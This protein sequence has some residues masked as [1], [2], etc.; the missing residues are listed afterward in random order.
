MKQHICAEIVPI[1]KQLSE[2]D[3]LKIS[4][5]TQHKKVTKGELLFTPDNQNE[6]MILASGS[7]KIYQLNKNGKEQLLRVMQP[8]E[9]EGEKAL[10]GIENQSLYAT[11]LK[12]STL[13][14]LSKTKFQE[15]L[16][17]YPEISQHLL[18]DFATKIGMLERQVEL[19]NS[20][21]VESKLATY[22]LDLSVDQRSQTVELPFKLKELATYL[23]TTPE[24]LSRKLRDLEDKKLILKK[25]LTITILN[26]DEL[27][28]IF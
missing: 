26:S 4:A 8:G 7:I 19:F 21:S 3:L 25:H 14:T 20:E 11:A 10:Y 16:S 1:F 22:I 18:A 2:A 23:G 28:D 13:C 17:E 5:I 12:D 9:F 24:T 27:E 6:L 15:L